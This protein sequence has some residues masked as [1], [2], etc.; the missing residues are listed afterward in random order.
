MH[1]GVRKP[2]A[3][4]GHGRNNLALNR[5]ARE[6]PLASRA[7]SARDT[8]PQVRQVVSVEDIAA[9]LILEC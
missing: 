8:A 5:A 7:P 2:H 4:I 3:H 6:N 1:V 9:S